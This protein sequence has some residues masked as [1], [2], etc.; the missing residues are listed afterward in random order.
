MTPEEEIA[1]RYT[2]LH[3]AVGDCARSML[4]GDWR[5]VASHAA[6]I[7]RHA[8]ALQDL[9]GQEPDVRLRSLIRAVL[10]R[11]WRAAIRLVDWTGDAA[12]PRRSSWLD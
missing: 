7:A 12:P 1:E 8:T 2:R 6:E 11:R 5:L 3:A 9:A 10:A 4:W